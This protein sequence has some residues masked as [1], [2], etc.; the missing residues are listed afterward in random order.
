MMAREFGLADRWQPGDVILLREYLGRARAPQLINV[1]PEIVVHDG[2]DYLA[3]LSQPGMTFMTRDVPGR[4]RMSVQERID[5]YKREEL[6][7]D[8]Y[9]RRVNRSVLSFYVAGA[10]HS[11]RVFWDAGWRFRHWYVNLEDPFVRTRSA[12][13]VNDHTLDIVADAGLK[14]SWKDEPEF[15]ALIE[16]GKIRPEK[17]RMV[18]DEGLRVI[19]RIEA[20]AWPFNE[21]WPEWRPDPSWTVPQIRDYWMP[22]ESLGL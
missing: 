12:I 14:W 7:H 21:P 3:L 17:A 4:N 1:L 8:W 13:G 10:S 22:S 20:R 11:I 16:A 2:P 9:E 5:L 18:R 6:V 15:A 19:Q